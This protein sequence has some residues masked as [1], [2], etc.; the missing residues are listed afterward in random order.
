MSLFR[1][2]VRFNREFACDNNITGNGLQVKFLFLHVK[3]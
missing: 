2:R 1:Y 3:S